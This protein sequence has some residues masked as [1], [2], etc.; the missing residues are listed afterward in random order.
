MRERQRVASERRNPHGV[1]HPASRNLS[2]GDCM[3]RAHLIPR[4]ASSR[5]QPPSRQPWRHTHHA[6]LS[7]TVQKIPCT[8]KQYSVRYGLRGNMGTGP[9]RA[10][11]LRHEKPY[12]RR[13]HYEKGAYIRSC[14]G[15]CFI[16]DS[17]RPAQDGATHGPSP[18]HI[19]PGANRSP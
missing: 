18:Q 8:I 3:E 4:L 15:P 6:T 10:G 5:R 13:T 14:A 9:P 7:T 1:R 17:L 12:R 11:P 19:S 16:V 2:A